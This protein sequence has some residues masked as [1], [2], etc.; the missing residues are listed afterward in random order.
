M[1]D[2]DADWQRAEDL[3]EVGRYAEAEQTVRGALGAAPDNA[4]LLTMLGYLL[5][6]QDRF[7][8]ALAACDAAVACAPAHGDAHAQRA[9]VLIGIHRGADAVLAATEAVRL[10]RHL[11]DRHHVLAEA[12][13]DD[14]RLDQARA[15]AREALRLAPRSAPAL[16]T[17]AQIE[18]IAGNLDAAG[19]AARRA[20]AIDPANTR[21]RRML[22]MLDADRGVVRRSIRALAEIARDRPADPDLIGLLW[23]IRR[24]VAAPRWWL[25]AAAA[26]SA[27][28]G[29]VAAALDSPPAAVAARVVAAVT[30][31]GT[32]GFV[33]RILLPAGR[34]PWRALRLAPPLV[35]RCL[36][37][38]L[39]VITAVLGLLGRYAA[40]GPLVPPV[41]A[42]VAGPI[43]WTCMMAEMLGH[44]LD[45]PGD[46]Q[47]LHDWRR[48]VR[49][50][51]REMRAWPAETRRS[52]HT[53]WHAGDAEQ[54][55][56]KQRQAQLRQP[57]AVYQNRHRNNVLCAAYG[58]WA[59]LAAVIA[60]TSRP[61]TASTIGFGL[62][63]LLLLYASIR[64]TAMKAIAT[65][66]GLILD[67]PLWKALVRWDQVTQVVDDNPDN[68]HGPVPIRAPTLLLTNGRRLTVRQ[69]GCYDLTARNVYR[70]P[71]N[72]IHHI[73]AELEA[74]RRTYS[75]SPD[76]SP[77]QQH[78][79]EPSA[80]TTPAGTSTRPADHAVTDDRGDNGARADP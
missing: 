64:V 20:L 4:G 60:V 5:H 6:R 13:V 11:A 55:Q 29:L 80:D 63:A 32:A 65:R 14:D 54:Q 38:G 18:R 66:E 68:T 10:G 16:L 72:P 2:I 46:R 51:L 37:T 61:Q 25:C 23:P 78:P 59:A 3:A 19:A 50:V 7:L 58:A 39:A 52:L 56:R 43:L 31:A 22:A 24:V 75:S 34:L 45:D 73:T 77:D 49:D 26:L 12:F 44:G 35:R 9:W 36:H 74:I 47:F 41:L 70:Q 40:G 53:A 48:Q 21:G 79:N 33:L 42:V 76:T 69:A 28:L 15:A 67:G 71:T 62:L 30:C 1:N 17:L 8:D 27:V 57:L